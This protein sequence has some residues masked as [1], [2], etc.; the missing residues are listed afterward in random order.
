LQP[1]NNTIDKGDLVPM[2]YGVFAKQVRGWFQSGTERVPTNYGDAAN[3][4]RRI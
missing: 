3:E 4:V 2:G 1:F